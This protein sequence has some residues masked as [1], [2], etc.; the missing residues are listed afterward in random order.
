MP[1]YEA[2]QKDI[3]ERGKEKETVLKAVLSQLVERQSK[4]STARAVECELNTLNDER[5]ARCREVEDFCVRFSSLWHFLKLNLVDTHLQLTLTLVPTIHE[6]TQTCQSIKTCVREIR[7]QIRS[8]VD[9]TPESI[10]EAKTQMRQLYEQALEA[11]S[12]PEA[13]VEHL[14]SPLSDKLT[15]NTKA[16]TLQS[17]E[18]AIKAASATPVVN[19]FGIPQGKFDATVN[20]HAQ[21]QKEQTLANLNIRRALIVSRWKELEKVIKKLNVEIIRQRSL[22]ETG[23]WRYETWTTWK[24]SFKQIVAASVGYA[25]TV[26]TAPYRFVARLFSKGEGALPQ[27]VTKQIQPPDLV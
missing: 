27:S 19:L 6:L 1:E 20:T 8:K 10:G 9:E 24:Y 15:K 11:S 25:G 3:T 18:D 26:V 23:V 22:V 13:R 5:E 14:D 17:I 21:Q 16:T 7:V 12:G 4:E 2:I